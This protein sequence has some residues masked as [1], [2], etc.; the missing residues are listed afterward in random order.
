M[1]T[2]KEET[3]KPPRPATLTWCAQCGKAGLRKDGDP[4]DE[5]CRYCGG[6]VMRKRFP[7]RSQAKTAQDALQAAAR[8]KARQDAA[9]RGTEPAGLAP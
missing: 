1:T 9:G 3:R 6:D 4:L 8:R 5:A 7:T 2:A